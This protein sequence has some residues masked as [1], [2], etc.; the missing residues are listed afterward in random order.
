MNPKW[1]KAFHSWEGTGFKACSYLMLISKL[2][3]S[4]A[5]CEAQPFPFPLK[6]A[7]PLNSYLWLFSSYSV[8]EKPASRSLWSYWK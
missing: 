7:G 3:A 1:K 6:R 8:E 2:I 4:A 5:F